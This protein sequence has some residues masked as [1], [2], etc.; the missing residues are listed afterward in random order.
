MFHSK[1]AR[2]AALALAATAFTPAAAAFAQ[3]EDTTPE[4]EVDDPCV[5]IQHRYDA[6]VRL[7]DRITARYQAATS[8]APA[9][10]TPTTGTGGPGQGKGKMKKAGGSGRKTTAM[11]AL[12]SRLVDRSATL[13]SLAEENGCTDLNIKA[14]TK[15]TP[16]T[17]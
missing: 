7:N 2:L 6:M 1:T 11:L 12:Q 5:G 17:T 16:K 3:T 15:L 8:A 14:L 10:T 13:V 9:P 4:A